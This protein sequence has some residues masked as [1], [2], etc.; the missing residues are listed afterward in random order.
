MGKINL[1]YST[2]NIAL[3]TR[4]EYMKR[5]IEKTEQFLRRLRWKAYPAFPKQ[6]QRGRKENIRIQIKKLP[7][8]NQRPDTFWR[9]DDQT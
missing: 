4:N 7:T 6:E 1:G 8:T 9:V 3:P 2:K 5:F